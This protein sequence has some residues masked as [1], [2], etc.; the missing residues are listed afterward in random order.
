M[1]LS[2]SG[3]QVVGFASYDP[4]QRPQS[5]LVGHNCILP[6]F[7]GQGFGRQQIREIVRRFRAMGIRMARASTAENPFFVPAQAMYTACGFRETGRHPWEG[8]PSH[9][10]IE[11][12][13]RLGNQ[14]VKATR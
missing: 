1:F 13:M 11:Y 10:V 7:H 3:D 5:G 8:D 6:E 4:R 14:G 2:W 12:E 9:D